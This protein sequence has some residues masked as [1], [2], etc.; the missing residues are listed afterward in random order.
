MDMKTL[1]ETPSWEWPEDADKTIL[2]ILRDRGANAN[3]RILAAELAGDLTVMDDE[4]A[5]ALLSIA[6]HGDESEELRAQ[7]ILSLGPALEDTYDAF[8][9]TDELTISP[10]MFKKIQESL[11]K[12]YLDP[13]VPEEV[14]R[15][16]LEA[17]VRAPEEWHHDAV[18]EAYLN[19]DEDWKL[20]AL[21]CM[22]F[23]GGFEDQILEAINSRNPEIYY[24]AILAAGEWG[25][26]DA[27]PQIVSILTGLDPDK[28]LL[29]AA[30]EAS[31]CIRPQEA[32]EI[33]SELTYS[34]DEDI[35]EAAHEAIAMSG[36][37]MDDDDFFNDDDETI[38]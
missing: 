6:K 15:M 17:S 35:V 21:F 30:I 8:D 28:S 26:Q 12:L 10:G 32:A 34:D 23:I 31:V 2:G 16:T 24:Q 9:D 27:W 38:H 14:R 13:T 18:A 33:L 1:L 19:A 29:L 7:A 4:L 11:R 20:T 5:G 37:Y 22:G 3:D 25:L 36:V